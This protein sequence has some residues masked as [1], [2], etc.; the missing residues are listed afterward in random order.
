VQSLT[1]RAAG[2]RVRPLQGIDPR[3]VHVGGDPRKVWVP[4]RL[5]VGTDAAAAWRNALPGD[6]RRCGRTG[7]LRRRVLASL[8]YA[9]HR[10][11]FGRPIG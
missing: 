6:G 7:W 10:V 4:D 9:N 5:I 1:V 2:V 11:Q 8:E 3:T